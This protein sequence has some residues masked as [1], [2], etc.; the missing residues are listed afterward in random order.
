MKKN[1]KVGDV[2]IADS[3]DIVIVGASISGAYFSLKMAEQG[4]S[5]LAIEKSSAEKLSTGYDI[6]ISPMRT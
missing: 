4:Y 2:R 5:V 3:Y 6:S 1:S